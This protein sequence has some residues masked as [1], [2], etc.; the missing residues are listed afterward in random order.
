LLKLPPGGADHWVVSTTESA[1]VTESPVGA[2][3]VI[4]LP[5]DETEANAAERSK[6]ASAELG[7][8]RTQNR[9]SSDVGPRTEAGWLLALLIRSVTAVFLMIHTPML[10]SFCALVPLTVSLAV[11][12]HRKPDVAEPLFKLVGEVLSPPSR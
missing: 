2:G 7:D 1:V 11:F 3:A 9:R 12:V 5:V 6:G 4:V 10:V 8:R